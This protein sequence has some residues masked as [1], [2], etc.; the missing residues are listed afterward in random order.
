MD[1]IFKSIDVIHNALIIFFIIFFIP[2]AIYVIHKVINIM[3]ISKDLKNLF[4]KVLWSKIKKLDTPDIKNKI[5]LT[6][7]FII[8]L[9]I[10]CSL[11]FLHISLIAKCLIYIILI[12]VFF[13]I[14]MLVKEI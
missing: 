12:S 14:S 5:I 6:S 9:I 10:G 7:T 13:K 1:I 2:I 8:F 3:G 4:H 11:C